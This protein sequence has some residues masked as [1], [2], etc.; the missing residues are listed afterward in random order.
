MGSRRRGHCNCCTHAE[1]KGFG[2][3]VVGR[4][5]RLRLRVGTDEPKSIREMILDLSRSPL[6]LGAKMNRPDVDRNGSPD[7]PNSLRCSGPFE[8]SWALFCFSSPAGG[9]A[10]RLMLKQTHGRGSSARDDDDQ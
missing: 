7:R 8:A 2:G 9:E 10:G 5:S 6:C 4:I 1:T 3:L